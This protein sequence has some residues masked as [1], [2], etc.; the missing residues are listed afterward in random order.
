[1]TTTGEVLKPTREEMIAFLNGSGEIDGLMFGE[2][3]AD[4]RPRFWWRKYLD[5]LSAPQGNAAQEG[6][7]LVPVEPT[8][9]MVEAGWVHTA[10]PCFSENVADAYKAMIAAAPSNKEVER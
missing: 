9:E 4:K 8:E 3:A 10:H 2:P 7:V 1:M 5:V 6:Y